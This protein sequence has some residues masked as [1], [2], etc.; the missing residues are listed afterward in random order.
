ME[1]VKYIKMNYLLLKWGLID[2]H[3]TALLC[4][5]KGKWN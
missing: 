1:N 4:Q 3:Q 5:N 2:T